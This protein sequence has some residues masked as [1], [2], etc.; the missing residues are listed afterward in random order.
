MHRFRHI[1]FHANILLLLSLSRMIR[2]SFHPRS[3]R[4]SSGILLLDL[5]S[6][7]MV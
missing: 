6:G 3:T 2:L 4:L 7:V 5:P 1:R